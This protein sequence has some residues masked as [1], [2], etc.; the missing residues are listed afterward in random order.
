MKSSGD[1]TS[2]WFIDQLDADVLQSRSSVVKLVAE[3]ISDDDCEDNSNTINS[4]ND[5]IRVPAQ[6]VLERSH[7]NGVCWNAKIRGLR[8]N[9]QTCYFN[10]IIQALASSQLFISFLKRQYQYKVGSMSRYSD[11]T[12][13]FPARIDDFLENL[14]D[15]LYDVNCQP[16]L[17]NGRRKN[18]L[19][20]TVLM[21]IFPKLNIWQ[22]Q[23]AQEFLLLLIEKI[24]KISLESP[25]K[26]WSISSLKCTKCKCVKPVQN[27]IFVTLALSTLSGYSSLEQMLDQYSSIS[28]IE[29]VECNECSLDFAKKQI[30]SDILMYKEAR[31]P[32]HHVKQQLDELPKKFDYFSRIR[33]DDEF[34]ESK[35]CDPENA[36]PLS[37][38]RQEFNKRE[39]V[40]R[41]PSIFV[42]HIHRRTATRKI[43]KHI[44]FPLELNVAK[45]LVGNNYSWVSASKE[46]PINDRT[47]I[48]PIEYTL[49]SVVE[50]LGTAEGG[51]YLTY[52]KIGEVNNERWVRVSDDN[53][54]FV[55]W[56]VVSRAEAY[57]LF[58]EKVDFKNSV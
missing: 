23:D 8:N 4:I 52:R 27:Q 15:L 31:N 58:Y 7:E 44:A 48:A 49:C 57:L 20:A 55:G 26:G 5:L 30:R 2:D 21:D 40:S 11:Q 32:G 47:S 25:M 29:D 10:S 35:F 45:H 33:S 18:S 46:I 1:M 50:H 41:P 19:A 37:I 38:L 12:R 16:A 22:Q 17:S 6:D 51:H 43:R 54:K 13:I 56:D 42:F 28:S 34:F 14:L 24:D 9:G 39:L 3:E 36:Q 53:W